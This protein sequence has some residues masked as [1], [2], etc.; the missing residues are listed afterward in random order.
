MYKYKF[1][2]AA[3]LA[4]LSNGAWAEDAV[5]EE[6]PV[7]ASAERKSALNLTK[8]NSTASRLGLSAM[9]T[10]ASVEVLEE[11]TI[12]QRGDSS[13]R[14]AIS[15]TTGL[16][17]IS[18]L[19]SGLSFSARGFTGNDSLAQAEDGIRL[20][21]A[22]STLTYPSDTWGYQR[23]EVLRGPASVLF[24]DGSVGGIINS[25]R[26]AP[27]RDTTAEALVGIGTRG[28][29]R[30]GIGG[31]TAVGEI[32][33]LR[34]DVSTTGGNGYVQRGEHKS[35][36]LMSNLLLT[37]SDR[38]SIN[39]TYDHA[40]EEPSRYTGIPLRNG[41]LPSSLRDSNYN[42]QNG[43]QDFTED[44]L[45]AKLEWQLSDTLKLTNVGY[46]FNSQR[47]WRNAE[48]YSLNDAN[49]TVD[50][51][52]YTEIKHKQKQ[53]GDRLELAS[54]ADF[55]GHA[56]RWALGY[57]VA[58]VDFTY[59]DNFYN[60]NDPSSTVPIQHF[61]PGQFTTIDPTVADY[62]SKTTQQALFAEDAFSLTDQL[63]LS[64]GL[65]Q[66]KINVQH[67]SHLSSASA[68]KDYT[69]FS[70]RLGVLWQASPATSWYAQYSKG[71]DPIS[72]LVSIRPSNT[73]FSLTKAEQ[74]ET[75]VKHVLDHGKGELTLA[76]YHIAKDDIIT[77]ASASPGSL[78]AQGGQ[79][80]SRGVEVSASLLPAPHWR[81]DLN[82]ALLDAR[83]DKLLITNGPGIPATNAS[84]NT[85]MNVPEKTA[86][87][88]LYYT[89]PQWEAGLG[90][91][92]VGK[93]YADNA[94]TSVMQGYTVY[95]A[96]VAWRAGART[97]L[98]ASIRNLTD[99]YYAPVAYDVQQFIV[100][101]SRRLEL[102]AELR[103]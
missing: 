88:W 12:R 3:I 65:R 50:R 33:S 77:R 70:Y 85:P 1:L 26:K 55:M 40:D 37:P 90:A 97:T 74:V 72:S 53:L 29:Y 44:R 47:H 46:W 89:Q 96:S 2:S 7:K 58:R 68:D 24:G 78:A 76:V 66:D 101:E 19:G 5:L 23:I 95:D 6:V 49:G 36:K 45:R 41:R 103:Y 79:Q 30:A 75:G 15:R 52:S 63:K 31:T 84:G 81:A 14:E 34:L 91:R 82:M 38:L 60:G 39:F 11:D 27:S 17:D 48:L 57:E 9:E 42:I 59:Y 28:E 100:G 22:A 20:L 93:R 87:A 83:F 94:N 98:R 86:N 61:D 71:S 18:N 67:H 35:G 51:F 54:T 16:T 13:V 56:N 92:L 32:G 102:I 69:P 4:A 10:P 64:A 21:T 25:I 62:S 99:K 73:P 80:S 8:P 43:D